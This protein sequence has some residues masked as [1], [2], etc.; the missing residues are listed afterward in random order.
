MTHFKARSRQPMVLR[1]IPGLRKEYPG[2]TVAIDGSD[3]P[4][5][6][7]GGDTSPRADGC[8]SGDLS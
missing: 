1:L 3:M 8:G 4:A 5:Y 2:R 7:N 6:A